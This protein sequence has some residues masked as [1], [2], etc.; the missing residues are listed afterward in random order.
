MSLPWLIKAF[1]SG[2]YHNGQPACLIRAL[3]DR[4]RELSICPRSL[5]GR[6]S[7]R[8]NLRFSC[9]RKIHC[10]DCSL[11]EFALD[12]TAPPEA[13]TKSCR[14]LLNPIPMPLPSVRALKNGSKI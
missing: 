11:A 10:E 6:F 8:F 5:I 4:P 7:G 14:E 12:L 1:G 9:D 13:L 2:R 3:A